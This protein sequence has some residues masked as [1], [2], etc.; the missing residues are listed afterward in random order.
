[1]VTSARQTGTISRHGKRRDAVQEVEEHMTYDYGGHKDAE[2]HVQK[3][4][5][6]ATGDI[7]EAVEDWLGHVAELR[8][9]TAQ[10]VERGDFATAVEITGRALD[11]ARGFA[12][13]LN[14]A[15]TAGLV[16]SAP[17]VAVTAA[18]HADMSLALLGL[19]DTTGATNQWEHVAELLPAGRE[20]ITHFTAV[21][22]CEHG[23]SSYTGRC[24]KR[25][26]CPP[27]DLASWQRERL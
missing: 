18:L 16:V 21:G 2:F 10:A 24:Y 5:M 19:G 14:G 9:E 12:R 1:M 4:G 20:A 27:T 6:D 25:P 22:V 23:N 17:V 11:E 7:N 13:R 8:V 15:A 3:A 26:P